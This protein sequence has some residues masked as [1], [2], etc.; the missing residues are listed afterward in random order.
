MRVKHRPS[1]RTLVGLF[2]FVAVVATPTEVA[3]LF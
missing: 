2:F 1:F 3:T